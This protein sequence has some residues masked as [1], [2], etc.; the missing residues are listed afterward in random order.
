MTIN[1]SHL[2]SIYPI[3]VSICHS[4]RPYDIINLRSTC[5]SIRN[6]IEPKCYISLKRLLMKDFKDPDGIMEIMLRHKIFL[7][8]GRSIQMLWPEVPIFL[9]DSW[10]FYADSDNALCAIDNYF[11][12]IEKLEPYNIVSSPSTGIISIIYYKDKIP[13][14]VINGG[15]RRALYR[16][17]TT[18]DLC[19]ITGHK[20]YV[21][22][23]EL[24]S[25]G[26]IDPYIYDVYVRK[27]PRGVLRYTLKAINIELRKFIKAGIKSN[28]YHV[29]RTYG[30]I[31]TARQIRRLGKCTV[32]VITH[33]YNVPL[34]ER[35]YDEWNYW[36]HEK[37]W[38]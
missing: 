29:T 38:V 4:L 24:A 6:A 1:F 10:N 26:I 35:I 19:F 15:I 33:N 21:L 7:H 8:G 3:T 14:Q 30:P 16:P 18:A 2:I 17:K 12:I 13:I 36:K 23:P 20:I 27:G 11:Q 25:R 22:K 37:V 9:N 31:K 28:Y 32:G 34:N 5:K